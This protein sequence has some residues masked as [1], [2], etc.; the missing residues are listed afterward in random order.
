LEDLPDNT[1]QPAKNSQ[2]NTE[3]KDKVLAVNE[4]GEAG[5][6]RIRQRKAQ[7]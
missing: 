6:E 2:K 7:K 3:T 1:A 5:L 4:D